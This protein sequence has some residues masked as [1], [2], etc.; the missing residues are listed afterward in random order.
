MSGFSSRKNQRESGREMGH[1]RPLPTGGGA[2]I[3]A[4]T[5]AAITRRKQ[6][7]LFWIRRAAAAPRRMPVYCG[8]RAAAAGEADPSSG[9]EAPG[10]A[11]ASASQACPFTE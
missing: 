5:T 8:F 9:A 10:S 3:P 2:R 6:R 4:L 7:R 11:F 1:I